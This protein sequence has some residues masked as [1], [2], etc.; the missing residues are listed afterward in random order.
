MT[1]SVKPKRQLTEAQRLAFLKGREKRLANLKAKREA[2]ESHEHVI[3]ESV[4]DQETQTIEEEVI[5]PIPPTVPEPI[6]EIQAPVD[7]PIPELK[8]EDPPI[9]TN[10]IKSSFDDET[11]D[12]IVDSLFIKIQ[13]AKTPVLLE[14]PKEVT[15][16]EKTP[17]SKKKTKTVVKAPSK[18]RKSHS[19]SDMVAPHNQQHFSWA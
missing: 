10:S 15:E 16:T 6:V 19:D 14:T 1:E 12:R 2:K 3:N 8:R 13:N 18:P 5:E 17:P 4:P 9:D 11:I 7:I